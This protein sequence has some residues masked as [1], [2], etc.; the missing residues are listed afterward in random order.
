MSSNS[1]R[2]SLQQESAVASAVIAGEAVGDAL[3]AAIAS[4]ESD[5]VV[6]SAIGVTISAALN[7]FKT[8]ALDSPEFQRGLGVIVTGVVN[9]ILGSAAVVAY[10]IETVGPQFDGF[11]K[12]LLTS[13]VVTRAL[14]DA[15]G[16]TATNFLAHRGFNTALVAALNLL[17]GK[18]LSGTDVS[19]ALSEAVA[20]LQADRAFQAA[21]NGVI[22]TTVATLLG[23]PEVWQAIGNALSILTVKILQQSGT[24]TFVVSLAG[25]IVGA[26]AQF[27]LGRQAAWNLVGTLLEDILIGKIGVTADDILGVVT[28]ELLAELGLQ[29]AVGLSIGAGIGFGLYCSATTSWVTSSS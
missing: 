2:R 6:R 15:L 17:A 23:P 19:A 27:L 16:A 28:R 10:V 7:V 21:V 14:A 1:P 24:A 8:T 9:Q 18:V 25:P 3:G 29:V 12:A 22:P 4:L 11:V 26:A 20:S 5:P 13:P